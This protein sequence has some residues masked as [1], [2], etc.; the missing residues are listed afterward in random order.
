MRKSSPPASLA[1]SRSY[2]I[3]MVIPAPTP[4]EGEGGDQPRT[5]EGEDRWDGTPTG[6]VRPSRGSEEPTIERSARHPSPF[7]YGLTGA[8]GVAVAYILLR[9]VIDIR[10]ILLY[11]GV[12]LFLAVGLD[13]AV[14]WLTRRGLSRGFAVV[15]I[16]VAFLLVV[17][18]FIAAA[19]PPI[20]HEAHTLSVNY[21]RYRDDL[22][23][24]R[25]WLGGLVKRFHLTSYLRGENAAK[26]KLSLEGGA[27]GAGRALLSAATATIVVVVLTIYF[28][29][30]LPAVTELWLGLVPLRPSR[31]WVVLS[32]ATS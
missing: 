19:V 2:S 25:G 26:L 10:S 7:Y 20:S 22:L 9:A 31:A 13:P 27:L 11:L 12:A 8:L 28:L 23:H 29:V 21:P 1:A 32:L 6:L 24:G 17:G 18:G 15:V 4:P 16:I 5:P 14:G 3:P 30:A